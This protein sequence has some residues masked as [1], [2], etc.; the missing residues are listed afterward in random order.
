MGP[1]VGVRQFLDPE[2]DHLVTCATDGGVN[3]PRRTMVVV[4]L[5]EVVVCTDVVVTVLVLM[6]LKIVTVLRGI[7]CTTEGLI[8]LHR[9]AVAYCWIFLH[10]V[11]YDGTLPETM[12]FSFVSS[13]TMYA[14]HKSL[15]TRRSSHENAQLDG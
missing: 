11:A 8:P 6:V 4:G 9:H 14:L 10:A 1:I 2:K 12:Y 7:S 15:S 13:D 5:T 3:L